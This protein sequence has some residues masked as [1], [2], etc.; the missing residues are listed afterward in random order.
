[1]STKN[2]DRTYWL[3]VLER[4]ATPVLGA[5]SEGRL[6]TSMPIEARDSRDRADYTH[7]E[8]LGRLLG[9]IAPWLELESQDDEEGRLRARF[10]E[11][12][13]AAIAAAV[14]PQSPDYCNFCNGSQPVVDASFLAL[15][16]VR[17]PRELW[18]KL[19]ER[20]QRNLV[21]ALQAT[22][23]IKP[24]WNNWLLFSAMIE[25]ALFRIGESWDKMRVDYAL[26]QHEQWYLGDGAYSDG[27]NFHWDYYNSFVIHPFMADIIRHVAQEDKHW[28]SLE[29]PILQ[30]AQR[31]AR[32]LELL[33][34][35]EGTIPPIG[36]S[37]PYRF[38]AL[39]ALG[40]A[41]LIDNLPP[42]LSPAAVRCAMTAV[43]RRSIEAPHTFDENGWLKIGFIGAQPNMGESYISTGS[44]YACALGFLP[45]GLPAA[46]SFWAAPPEKWTAQKIYDGE[47]M[48]AD[49][50]I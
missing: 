16:M 17:A 49:K 7:L 5:L 47:D 12:A 34:S 50:A 22:R 46:H 38:G 25:V 28:K 8:A 36:R 32:V 37:L 6:K 18:E 31:Y 42:Q 20:A 21:R 19:D 9:G 29:A 24:G 48:P 44:L 45:L 2:Q 11:Q 10:A 14:D 1:M 30:R 3:Q 40:H 4:I 27:A 41:A 13:R 15:A 23:V 33:I 35:P 39:H 26:R 43:M